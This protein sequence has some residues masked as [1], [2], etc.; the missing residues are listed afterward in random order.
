MARPA[1]KPKI[2]RIA[3]SE[4]TIEAKETVSVADDL[5]RGVLA[6]MIGHIGIKEFGPQ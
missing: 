3:D 1:Q 6:Q 4:S 5:E 2:E